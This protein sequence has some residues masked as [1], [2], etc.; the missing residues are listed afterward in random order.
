MSRA[1]Q[2]RVLLATVLL[3]VLFYVVPVE[4]GAQGWRLVVRGVGAGLILAGVAAMVVWQIRRRIRSNELPLEGLAIALVAGAIA[5]ALADFVVAV[6]APG[7]FDG[8]STR[9]DALYFAL[10]TL[11]TVG[12]GDINAAGQGARILLCF[13]M[14]FNIGVLATGASMLVNQVTRRLQARR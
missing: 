9:T 3:L 12:F 13:Q 14:L 1:A 6:S 8:L 2:L 11:F 4:P 10:S 5:F 7:Q